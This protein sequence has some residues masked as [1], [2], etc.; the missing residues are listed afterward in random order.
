MVIMCENI[1]LVSDNARDEE[2][3]KGIISTDKYHI[4]SI[5]FNGG[6][7]AALSDEGTSLIM[8]DYDLI[9]DKA[10]IFYS[11]QQEKSKACIIFYGQDIA[12]EELGIMLHQ[13]IYAYIP[14]RFL[15]E[16]L[17]D[18]VIGGLENRRAFI[19]I[20]GMMDS[21]K[22]LNISLE[23]EK[24]SLKKKNQEL[25]FINRLSSEISYDVSWDT[26]LQRMISVGLDR[27]FEY[28]VFGLLFNIGTNWKL[29]LHMFEAS[30]ISRREELVKDIFDRVQQ[31]F[32]HS[33]SANNT[34]FEFIPLNRPGSLE[35]NNIETIPL[36]LAGK[37]LGYV[38]YGT[39]DSKQSKDETDILINTLSNML[40]LS[41][42]NA[43]EYH[44]LKEASVTDALTD[45][46][47]R[48]GLFDFLEKEL[49]RAERHKKPVSFILTDMDDFKGINDTMG[50]QAGD[51]VLM[52]YASILKKSF[53]QSDIVARFGGDEF[54]ILLPET[55]LK[56][57]HSIMQRVVE[58]LDQHT[59]EWEG[60]RFNANISYGISGSDELISNTDQDALIGLSDARLYEHKTHRPKRALA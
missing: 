21:L 58:T 41:L 19:E 13:G 18:A 9:R 7:E 22:D 59:F 24:E 33:I 53:R 3:L 54:A 36:I 23:N 57:A 8:A 2:V 60:K 45:V 11:L 32:N 27:A 34:D 37:I 40:S 48:K 49:P 26:L 46:F 50:H 20:L 39:G 35:C 56:E 14:K 51:Y 43:L 1:L 17:R 12:S 55:G 52:E 16:R 44:R 47:N 30:N 6:V 38:I 28:R 10:P 15:K 31:R 29:A 4:T 25:R 5:P 42:E